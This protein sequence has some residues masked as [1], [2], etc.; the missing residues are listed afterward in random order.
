MELIRQV[1]QK[2]LSLRGQVPDAAFAAIDDPGPELGLPME[3][4]LYTP[5]FKAEIRAVAVEE[6]G[7][8][9]LTDALFEQ[10]YVD[11][12]RLASN[13]RRA[14]QT[15]SQVSLAAV[16]MDN[17]I[18]Q[19][20]AELLDKR[21]A[22]WAADE[23]RA[24]NRLAQLEQERRGHARTRDELTAAIS[25]NGGN[26]IEQIRG[27]IARIDAS[28]GEKNARA[29]Q[30]EL[31]ASALG[32][33]AP[34]D[35]DTFDANRDAIAAGQ[36]HCVAQRDERGNRL[37]EAGVTVRELRKLHGE[38][39]DELESLRKRR[40]NIPRQMLMLRQAL[41][42]ALSI[43]P[44]ALP[45]I[46]E[47]IQVRDSERAWEGA[48][49]RL[50]HAFGLSLLVPEQHYAQVAAWAEGT[51]LG[52]R[53]VYYR[54]RPLA[55]AEPPALH[56]HSLVRKLS[57]QP[58]SPFYTWIEGEL[59]RR[60][61]YACCNTMDQF[62]REQRAITR[63]GQV[64]SGGERHEKDDRRQ[65]GDRTSYVLGWSNEA[66]IAALAKQER[67]LSTRITEHTRQ[68]LE[69][70]GEAAEWGRVLGLWQQLAVFSSFAELDWRPLVAAI[71]RLE[72]EQQALAAS[73]DLLRTLQQQL[74]ELGEVQAQVDT[75]YAQANASLA[76][77]VEKLRQ[78]RGLLGECE[79][80]AGAIGA[81]QFEA[82]YGLLGKPAQIRFRILD[83]RHDIGGC[84]DL[85]LAL[86][87]AQFA[88][89]RSSVERVFITENEVNALAFPDVDAS[90]VVFGGGYGIERL[91]QV[92]WLRSRQLVYWG[93][94]D[95][96]G[97][98]ILDRLRASLPG[99][100]SVLMDDETLQAHRQVWGQE[101][102]DKRYL[103]ELQR[104]TYDERQLFVR[105]RDNLVDER[106]RL[107]QERIGYAWAVD[108]IRQS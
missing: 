32:L 79:E 27:E 48:A 3:R 50:L 98:A 77:L 34:F 83:R 23:E 56:P 13:V 39:T 2:A 81:R 47:L 12:A 75:H 1:E 17:P 101:E 76:T 22:N 91:A 106:L 41:C 96:H 86:P 107:E 28:R 40:S 14:L 58:E 102:V 60:F 33:P 68:I 105:L 15:R 30:Y 51:H 43:A 66:K 85:A 61:D 9:V 104:L 21:I 90:M 84:S 25:A 92:D 19:G 82:R 70:K 7:A 57:I 67:D 11:Q 89:L 20:L 99:V 24:A 93:D 54:V 36:S 108:A 72:R 4:V 46:G 52:A 45:F 53:L 62:R 49:E 69:L 8:T 74:R 103:G 26:R 37:T 78:L 44:D 71:D 95:T 42:E 16:V 59:A 35:A 63:N 65:I 55:A 94:I 73:S 64:K 38:L 31:I 10:V 88:A 100:R 87:V 6:D 5:P 18:E 97:F 80:L 29:Q